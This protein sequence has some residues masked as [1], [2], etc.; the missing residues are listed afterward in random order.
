MLWYFL[1]SR[2]KK[3]TCT[4][5]KSVL[6]NLPLGR[7]SH[8][9]SVVF[10]SGGWGGRSKIFSLFLLSWCCLLHWEEE[11]FFFFF[12]CL[13]AAVSSFYFI[14]PSNLTK[15]STQCLI[16]FLQFYLEAHNVVQWSDKNIFKCHINFYDVLL[17]SWRS[18]W[19]WTPK[20]DEGCKDGKNSFAVWQFSIYFIQTRLFI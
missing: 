11:S 2:G 1:E 12:S 8:R 15:T 14:V 7:S 13:F 17:G 4:G 18:G 5:I 16:F 19:Y 20:S 3:I 6:D 10:R 9:C